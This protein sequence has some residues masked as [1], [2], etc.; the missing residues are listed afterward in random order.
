MKA[1]LQAANSA[2]GGAAPAASPGLRSGGAATAK[3]PL[4][5]PPRSMSPGSWHARAPREAAQP[6][7]I[8]P[9]A[10]DRRSLSQQPPGAF[11]NS[12]FPQPGGSLF[13]MNPFQD[14]A[15]AG[16]GGGFGALDAFDVSG[17]GRHYG[18]DPRAAGFARAVSDGPHGAALQQRFVDSLLR[19]HSLGHGVPHH[20]VCPL[21][22]AT[23]A[24]AQTLSLMHLLSDRYAAV[25]VFGQ[26]AV[27]RN[28]VLS[29]QQPAL[30]A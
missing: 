19:P 12:T 10:G 2:G 27:L 5:A 15:D 22:Y 18:G 1:W 16:D 9:H 14:A 6:S 25:S 30:R 21:L 17:F 4:S 23:T 20:Q 8:A 29:A 13:G 26:A 24:F 7:G 28:S 11:R 3:P